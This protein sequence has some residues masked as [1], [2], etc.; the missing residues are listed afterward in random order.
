[1][2]YLIIRGV[3]VIVNVLQGRGA[4]A[5]AKLRTS[6]GRE[7]RSKCRRRAGTTQLMSR[8]PILSPSFI[9]CRAAGSEKSNARG[10]S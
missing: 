7:S 1:M 2:V 8:S 10:W 3:I 9:R 5:M 4:K 6:G